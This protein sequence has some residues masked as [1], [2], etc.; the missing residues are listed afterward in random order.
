[1]SSNDEGVRNLLYN[2]RFYWFL[3]S[4]K[5]NYKEFR[6]LRFPSRTNFR[7]VVQGGSAAKV[8]AVVLPARIRQSR[9]KLRHGTDTQAN[10]FQRDKKPG[11]PCA[12]TNGC[13]RHNPARS[14]GSKG[15]DRSAWGIE[16]SENH[17]QPAA[18][19]LQPILRRGQASDSRRA[20]PTSPRRSLRSCRRKSVGRNC[21]VSVLFVARFPI[22]W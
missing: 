4:A 14:H 9:K 10:C 13:M 22:E 21:G 1:M 15:T 20:A 5:R 11:S 3:V 19:L 18:R 6:C 17:P 2:T 8:L 12:C 16:K 7:C